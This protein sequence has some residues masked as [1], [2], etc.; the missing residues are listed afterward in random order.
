MIKVQGCTENHNKFN[1]GARVSAPVNMNKNI[2]KQIQTG[3]ISA[4][5]VPTPECTASLMVDKLGEIEYGDKILEPSA[6][7]GH[8]ADEICKKTTFRP[9]QIDVVE[10]VYDLRKVLY[11]KGYNL[12]G[13]D[14]M[15]Y[16]PN[17]Q[18]DKIIMNPPFENSLDVIHTCYCF[19]NLLKPNGTLVAVLPEKFFSSDKKQLPDWLKQNNLKKYYEHLQEILENN[20][21]E[22]IKLGR[23]FLKSDV[24]DDVETRIVVIEK[25]NG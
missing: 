21:S 14:I 9:Y 10:P 18:Y 16:K 19:D 24:P 20:N 13:Y 15:E 3:E 5:F 25:N 7:C 1:F 22:T 23:V 4:G 8:I 6:G 11:E 17:F 2:I 12:V